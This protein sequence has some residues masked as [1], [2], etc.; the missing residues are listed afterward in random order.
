MSRC[1]RRCETWLLDRLEDRR[2]WPEPAAITTVARLTAEARA[3]EE[4]VSVARLYA[5]RDD[6]DLA[7]LIAE[8]VKGE[9]V[10]YLAAYRYTD[11]GPAEARRV[12]E[13]VGAAAARGC[14]RGRRRD[15]SPAEVREA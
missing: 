7:A 12:A 5:G 3:D 14:W 2:Y 4:F 15:P 8:L 1:R 6:V 10:A 11:A 9:S 13:D